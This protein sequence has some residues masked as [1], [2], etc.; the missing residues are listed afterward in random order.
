MRG[1]IAQT[2]SGVRVVPAGMSRAATSVLKK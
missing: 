2:A 1:R